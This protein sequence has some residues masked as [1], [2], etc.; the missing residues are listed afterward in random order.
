MI[1]PQD[2]TYCRYEEQQLLRK[3]SFTPAG[4]SISFAMDRIKELLD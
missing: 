3:D 2:G 1:D 4:H